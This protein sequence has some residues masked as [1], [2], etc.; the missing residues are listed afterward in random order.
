MQWDGIQFSG[1]G[2]AGLSFFTGCGDALINNCRFDDGFSSFGVDAVQM[3]SCYFSPGTVFFLSSI[4]SMS[5]MFFD[6]CAFG[7]R[8]RGTGD[9]LFVTG[10]SLVDCSG[11]G[12]DITSGFFVPSIPLQMDRMNINDPVGVGITYVTGVHRLRRTLIEGCPGDAVRALNN[13][14][15]VFQ[16]TDGSV[17]NAGFGLRL[18]NGAQAVTA[19][20]PPPE[21]FEQGAPGARRS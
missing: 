18:S 20:A 11:F 7:W 3:S 15:L 9:A 13:C 5:D 21:L 2:F 8:G 1:A 14:H 17:G 12:Q 6:G 16:N 19:G 4:G 10:I